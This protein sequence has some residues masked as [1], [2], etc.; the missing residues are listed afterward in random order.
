[1]QLD[2]QPLIDV[3]YARNRYYRSIDYTRPVQPSLSDE[4]TA[5][6]AQQLSPTR[7]S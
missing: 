7:P 4:E 3:I 2:L 1:V 6:L 5:F